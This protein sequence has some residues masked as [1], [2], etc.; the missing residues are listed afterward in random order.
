MTSPALVTGASSHVPSAPP[1][2]IAVPK[3]RLLPEILALLKKVGLHPEASFFDP[4]CRQ[5]VFETNHPELRLV[6][7]RA[8]DVPSVVAYGGASLGFAGQDVLAEFEYEELFAPLD[9]RIG[10][11]Y[12]ALV[13][14]ERHGTTQPTTQ[15]Q[16]PSQTP[17]GPERV[18]TKYP[19]LTRRFFHARYQHADII[20]LHGNV[21]I[22]SILGIC[23][24]IVDLVSTGRTL[25]ANRL[26]VVAK[27]MEVT[28]RLIIQRTA[29]KIDQAR[30]QRLIDQL[31]TVVGPT[32]VFQETLQAQAQTQ[33]G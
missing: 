4:E 6:L 24:R 13:E 12:L 21:E 15:L 10:A 18:A 17:G 7:V 23:P 16:A 27:L 5:L 29:Y 28:T 8:F 25:K 11:C 3:G 31:E 26:K 14:P 9:L 32:P 22:A 20:R 33:T 2:T 19:T 1:L 30:L